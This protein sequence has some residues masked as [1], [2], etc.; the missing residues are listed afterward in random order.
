MPAL[1]MTSGSHL[2]V[3]THL[4]VFRAVFVRVEQ[5]LEHGVTCLPEDIDHVFLSLSSIARDCSERVFA[6]GAQV[7][8]L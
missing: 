5:L 6:L 8:R 1:P 2:W 3:D 4:D 7:E